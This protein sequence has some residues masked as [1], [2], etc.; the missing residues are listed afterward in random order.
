MSMG[1]LTAALDKLE[2]ALRDGGD[3]LDGSPDA[4]TLSFPGLV[5]SLKD[6]SDS[7]NRAA[8]AIEYHDPG[9]YADLRETRTAVRDIR[10]KLRLQSLAN[11]GAEFDAPAA[12]FK[13]ANASLALVERSMHDSVEKKKKYAKYVNYG[14]EVV[15]AVYVIVSAVV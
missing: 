2:D 4:A 3:L 11:L 8:G 6:W 14:V 13:R 7:L 5:D 9:L 1:D 15:S 10:R 12:R